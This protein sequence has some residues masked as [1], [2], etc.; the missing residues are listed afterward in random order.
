MEMVTQSCKMMKK[1]IECILSIQEIV[2]IICQKMNNREDNNLKASIKKMKETKQQLVRSKPK[3]I[4]NNKPTT[5]T[6][7]ETE[8]KNNKTQKRKLVT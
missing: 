7:K 1:I 2:L 3:A 5:T 8:V 4:E 6:E